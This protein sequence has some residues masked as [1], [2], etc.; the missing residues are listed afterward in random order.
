MN[1]Q[2]VRVKPVEGYGFLRGE[3][4]VERFFHKSGLV[5]AQWH[6]VRV[7]ANVEFDDE[8]SERGARA[9]NVVLV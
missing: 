6:E 9:A 2:V 1:G 4:G 3:D 5:N 7:G 8:E